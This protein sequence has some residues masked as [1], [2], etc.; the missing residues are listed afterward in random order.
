[1]TFNVATP[2]AD[3]IANAPRAFSLYRQALAADGSIDAKVRRSLLASCSTAGC[4]PLELV[5]SSLLGCYHT[6]RFDY[7]VIRAQ[8]FAE[9]AKKYGSASAAEG[10]SGALL[11]MIVS[12]ITRPLFPAIAW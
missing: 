6:T 1:M 8:K 2:T 5:Y 3:D 11:A 10:L 7:T 12:S 4:K 9:L